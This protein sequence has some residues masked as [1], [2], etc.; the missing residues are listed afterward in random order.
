MGVYE[1]I[2][3]F[4]AAHELCGEATRMAHP[5]TRSGYRL[6]VACPC[7]EVLDR[8][9]TPEAARYDLVHSNLLTSSN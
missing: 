1:D 9:V 4:I 7:G 3:Q 8:W 6:M 2:R 5:P